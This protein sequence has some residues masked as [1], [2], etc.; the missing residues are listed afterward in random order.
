[1]DADVLKFFGVMTALAVAGGIVVTLIA[2][3]AAIAKR[4]ER[5]G[6]IPDEDLEFL[7]DRADEV[8][9]LRERVM[10]LENRLD[11]AERLL[12][13]PGKSDRSSE[14]A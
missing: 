7:R 4:I 1:M 3:G 12:A 11:F 5:K 6:Q 13:A 8:E 2:V 14:V 10:E 9:S